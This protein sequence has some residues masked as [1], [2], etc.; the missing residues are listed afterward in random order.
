MIGD[1]YTSFLDDLR[2][3]DE[4]ASEAHAEAGGQLCTDDGSGCCRECG[5]A[6]GEQCERCLGRGYHFACCSLAEPTP[7][8]TGREVV[9]LMDEADADAERRRVASAR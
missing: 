9:A 8:P 3:A 2:A 4:L 5:V 7:A 1:A 6:L